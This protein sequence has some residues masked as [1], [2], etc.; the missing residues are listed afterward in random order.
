MPRT[1]SGAR[2]DGAATTAAAVPHATRQQRQAQE[3][4]G[5]QTRIDSVFP[6]SKKGA[7]PYW[8]DLRPTRRH[9]SGTPVGPGAR[10]RR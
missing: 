4:Q 3:A 1:R 9:T 10:A 7:G 6:P 5:R 8:A 2:D